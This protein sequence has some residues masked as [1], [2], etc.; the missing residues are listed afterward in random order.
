VVVAVG[1]TLVEP[2]AEA[3]VKVPGVME[4]VVAPAVDQLRLLLEPKLMLVG[5]AVNELMVGLVPAGFTVMVSLKV[6]EPAELV[7]VRV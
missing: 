4:R 3:E 5:M 1:L 6:V 7:A 2:A